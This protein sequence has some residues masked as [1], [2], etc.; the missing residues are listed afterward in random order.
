M[1]GDCDGVVFDVRKGCLPIAVLSYVARLVGK[2][3]VI[4]SP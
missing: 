4:T 3:T 1:N 2:A